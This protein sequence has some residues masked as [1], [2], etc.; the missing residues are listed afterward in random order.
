[1]FYI[2]FFFS[3]FLFVSFFFYYYLSIVLAP[4][5]ENFLLK[6]LV[7]RR[8][9]EYISLVLFYQFCQPHQ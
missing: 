9:G 3:I 2:S 5:E 6:A 1:M 4:D 8:I 7:F